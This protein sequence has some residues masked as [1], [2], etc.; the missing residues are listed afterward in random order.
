MKFAE[1][2]DKVMNSYYDPSLENIE[3]FLKIKVRKEQDLAV[4]Q[5]LTLLLLICILRRNNIETKEMVDIFN[6]L[7]YLIKTVHINIL[8]DYRASSTQ[9]TRM[10]LDVFY[11]T[12]IYRLYIVERLYDQLNFDNRARA[13]RVMRKDL[14]RTDSLFEWSYIKYW[15]YWLDKVFSNYGTSFWYLA[16]MM[17]FSVALFWLIYNVLDVL[18][19]PNYFVW[20]EWVQRLDYYIYISLCTFS[21]LWADTSMA[22][23]LLLRILFGL[24]Q[25]IWLVIFWIFVILVWK[26]FD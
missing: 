25:V 14:E 18:Y 12:N 13:I 24:E 7:V 19:A 23:N 9:Y 17:I 4:K 15:Y 1:I 20:G 21:N 16:M 8:N 6:D 22:W 5:E 2:Y 10:L 11:K 3:K 26:R